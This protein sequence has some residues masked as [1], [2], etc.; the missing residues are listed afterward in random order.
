MFHL[1]PSMPW[2]LKAVV[3]WEF[4]PRGKGGWFVRADGWRWPL[5][6]VW[7][8]L[9]RARRVRWFAFYWFIRALMAVRLARI[10]EG[11]TLQW[12]SI[13]WGNDET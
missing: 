3:E 4:T 8:T 9:Y 7:R 6:L 2:K 10:D 13:K 11:A 5:F 12:R 1:M